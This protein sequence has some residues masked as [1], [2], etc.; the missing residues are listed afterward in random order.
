M[1]SAPSTQ[2]R[3]RHSQN[4]G[5]SYR[6]I[7]HTRR[8]NSKQRHVVSTA[9]TNNRRH[10]HAFI[11]SN[12]NF[13]SA[14]RQSR[15]WQRGYE[16]EHLWAQWL[17]RLTVQSSTTHTQGHG[18]C[19]PRHGETLLLSPSAWKFRL[20]VSLHVFPFLYCLFGYMSGTDQHRNW[21]QRNRLQ[22]VTHSNINTE[23]DV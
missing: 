12:N 5:C 16:T 14:G 4:Q 3:T 10:S 13:K 21:R 23:Q 11:P 2:Y 18:M 20:T 15:R 8:T 22:L 17:T 6:L 7:T 19:N 1:P 9:T